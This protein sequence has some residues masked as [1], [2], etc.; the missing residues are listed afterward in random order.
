MVKYSDLQTTAFRSTSDVGDKSVEIIKM[1]NG[2][3]RKEGLKQMY[4]RI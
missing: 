3:V 4:K 1:E 2:E